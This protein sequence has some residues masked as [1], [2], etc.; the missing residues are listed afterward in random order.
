MKEQNQGLAAEFSGHQFK[1]HMNKRSQELM[2]NK[3]DALHTRVESM[4]KE[5][6]ALLERKRAERENRELNMCTFKPQRS[7]GKTSDK[8]LKKLGRQSSS[9]GTLDPEYFF[10]YH[11]EKLRRNAIRQQIVTEMTDR[12]L[13]FKPSQN[14]NS[15][16]VQEKLAKARSLAEGALSA[17]VSMNNSPE[18]SGLNSSRRGFG[19][20][21]PS[22]SGKLNSSALSTPRT[23]RTKSNQV[24]FSSLTKQSAQKIKELPNKI[25]S[26]AG[27]G[28]PTA[29][30]Y[31]GNPVVVE[32]T[33]PYKNNTIEY[34]TVNI[35]G[36]I[37]YT[38]EF[39]EN[40]RT[41]PIHD[42]VKFFV[43]DS[44]IEHY[45]SG[46]Y[47]GGMRVNTTSGFGNTD[48]GGKL[49][50]CNWPGVG[51]RP[52]LV[53][54]A[55]RFVVC[56]RTNGSVTDWGFKLHATPLMSGST[57][58][59]SA[60]STARSENQPVIS[61]RGK[62]YGRSSNSSDASHGNVYDRLHDQAMVK[63]VDQHN[64]NVSILVGLYCCTL[65]R[66]ICFLT[67]ACRPN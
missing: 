31:M 35:H 10:K 41:E 28:D 19:G 23:P 8:I 5:R 1:P 51:G 27:L 43:D 57:N 30:D 2:A 21:S 64:K 33:H 13:T 44:H 12:E 66:I 11:E 63:A 59:S 47:S 61:N 48:T 4:R 6:E 34:T 7:G 49:T 22:M 3:R 24:P 32:S 54:P 45:G 38:I 16:A 60:L 20:A 25:L 9:K 46:K 18:K 55:S 67:A 37:S 40:T 29:G 14:A 62:L 52:A 50:P 42:Y 36:A 53:I 39:D 26:E 17:N 65:L 56:F 58:H 15:V